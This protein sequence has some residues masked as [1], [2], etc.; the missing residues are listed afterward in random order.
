MHYHFQAEGEDRT[1][2]EATDDHLD[3]LIQFL[4]Q[5]NKIH[6]HLDWHTPQEWLGKNPF[7]IEEKNGQIQAI[8]CA[9][10]ENNITAWVRAFGASQHSDLEKVW[11]TLLEP[12][13]NV[14]QQMGINQLASLALH[15]WFSGLLTRSAFDHH[16]NI[17]VLEWQG[18]LPKDFR[19]Q[20]DVHIR[21][22]LKGDLPDIAR[23]DH[24]AFP[25]LWQNSLSGLTKAFQQPGICTVA[26]LNNKIVGYQI[27]TTMTIYG[28]LARLAVHPAYQRKGIAT[29]L[30][31]NLLKQ[32]KNRGF[33]RITVNTQSD[34]HSSLKLYQKFG[35]IPTKEEIPVY[36]L[37]I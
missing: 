31:D 16:Q 10:P 25:P 2:I 9:I 12:A 14:L 6:R 26:R 32:F 29:L 36:L 34:N 4:N 35:F 11:I 24:L 18:D 15:Q 22:M 23:L 33:W 8:L 21:P 19:Y 30:V 17:I 1:I 13:M 5:N 7:L 20:D 27:S 37:N 3:A 28:H